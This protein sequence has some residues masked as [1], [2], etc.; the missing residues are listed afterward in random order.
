MP[1]LTLIAEAC[2]PYLWRKKLT[3]TLFLKVLLC[4]RF[5]HVVIIVSLLRMIYPSVVPSTNLWLSQ[6]LENEHHII[7]FEIRLKRNQLLL[8]KSRFGGVRLGL[9]ALRHVKY[10]HIRY[11][12]VQARNLYISPAVI[13][14]FY[15]HCFSFYVFF[16]K[17]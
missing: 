16:P 12:P 11:L 7:G 6:P 17:N 10:R 9:S 4:R 15:I 14:I 2:H 1:Q 13:A 3:V 8:L 5:I